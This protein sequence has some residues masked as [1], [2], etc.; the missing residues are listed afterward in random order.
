MREFDLNQL[1]D[2]RDVFPEL[3]QAQF[4]T[5]MLYSMGITKKEIG[6]LRSVSYSV[7]KETLED[8]KK[9]MGIYSLNQLLSIF[10]VRLVLYCLK[11][12]ILKE[13]SK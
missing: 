10:Q 2:F 7:V 8:I 1:S 6:M 3:T 4:E 9:R 12:C 5:G 11:N 13:S